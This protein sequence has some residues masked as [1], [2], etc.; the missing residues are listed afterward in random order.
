MGMMSF[1]AVCRW[2]KEKQNAAVE[3]EVDG[4]RWR[5]GR[6]RTEEARLL[7]VTARQVMGETSRHQKLALVD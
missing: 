4:R 7:F 3:Y 2:V 5:R 1:K 6:S